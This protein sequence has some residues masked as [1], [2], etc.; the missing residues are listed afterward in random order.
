VPPKD[1]IFAVLGPGGL[2]ARQSEHYEHRP[3]QIDMARL[4]RRVLDER[5]YALI[6]AGTGTGKT[7]AYLLPAILSG[8]RLV[9]STAT[10][11]LQEQI[12][13]KDL[14]LL[15][16]TSG[17]EFKATVMKGR[18]NYLCLARLERAQEDPHFTV[19]TREDARA[20]ALIEKWSGETQTGDRAELDLPEGLRIWRELSATS[21][22]CLGQRCPVFEEC[23]VTRMRRQAA[24]SDL[25]IVNHHLFF[26]DLALKTS[27]GAGR[28][29]EVI[30]RYDA[31][32][33]D[34][35][36]ALEDVA[37]EFFGVGASDYRVEDLV[38]DTERLLDKLEESDDVESLLTKAERVSRQFFRE[39]AERLPRSREPL[40]LKAAD[41]GRLRVGAGD[42]RDVLLALKG[43]LG[44]EEDVDV[45]NIVRRAR[46][47]VD[48]LDFLVSVDEP[49]FVYWAEGRA[50]ATFLRAAPIDV[51]EEL[52]NRLYRSVDTVVFTSAT[53]TAQGR[54]D[55]V[56]QRL[57]LSDPESGADLY[58]VE[59]LLL[60]S[61]FDY[62]TQAALYA[63]THLPE[64][65]DRAFVEAAAE[66]ILELCKLTDG[67]AFVLFTSLRNMN[68][69]H[70]RLKDRLPY[71]VL[72]QGERP[73]QVLIEEFREKPSVLFA[74]H[75]FWEGVDIAGE[76]LSL[77]IIDKLPFASPADPVVAA[78]VELLESRGHD[79][80]GEYQVPQAA[81]AL[82]Q[83]FGR[84][85]RSRR[86]RGVV[87]VLDRRLTTRRYG[88][89][90]LDS[91]PACPRTDDRAKI[92][93]WWRRGRSG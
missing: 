38:H 39:V 87:A 92:A 29:A 22:T 41:A 90:F 36:H 32:V 63:P 17:I 33:F 83:G 66:E 51:A 75:S 42:L 47:L 73:K 31:V 58:S 77:V 8:R 45:Q 53:L 59:T 11:T 44:R 57:G 9:L 80:F 21:D 93:G 49:G 1:P 82:R 89:A 69:V 12:V 67:R 68:E 5:R 88:R 78:R 70:R 34:E 28:G 61:P 56:K 27:R 4:V 10:K 26:A 20:L 7:L 6:E 2:L 55:F 24:D 81:L 86:D 50:R 23:F 71:R 18:G 16:R 35:A 25:L 43:R 62:R 84:L 3:Q 14:P 52:S 30:P 72:L 37:T 91:L 40:R 74:A 76:A 54:F 64:P 60:D 46:E 15:E 48:D 65:T 13:N 19:P 85:I 79:A